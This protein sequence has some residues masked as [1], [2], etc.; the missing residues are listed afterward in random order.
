[1]KRYYFLLAAAAILDLAVLPWLFGAS[2]LPKLV[3]VLLPF[4][5]LFLN[6]RDLKTVF[7][8]ALIYL[9]VVSE[10]NLGIL[11]LALVLFLFFERWFLTNFFHRSSWQTLA[12]SGLGVAVFYAAIFGLSLLFTPTV[13]IFSAG[14]LVPVITSALA[15]AGASFLLNKFS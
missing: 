11:F 2:W 10:F 1:M 3:L 15:A 9:R 6:G 12:L 4:G 14:A 8:L 13:F 7:V 5:F